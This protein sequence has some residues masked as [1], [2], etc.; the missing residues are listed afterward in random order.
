VLVAYASRDVAL[1]VVQRDFG[2]AVE[3]AELAVVAEQRTVGAAQ[4]REL[5]AVVVFDDRDTAF[6]GLRERA[7][8]DFA[9]LV[10]LRLETGGLA[11]DV[12]FFG[13]EDARRVVLLELA[14]AVA[15][16]VEAADRGV[17]VHIDRLAIPERHA[18]AIFLLRHELA[19]VAVAAL[20]D[21][22]FARVRG[23]VRGVHVLAVHLAILHG[24]NGRREEQ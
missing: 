16:F 10:E 1:G 2:G 17:A 15:V 4:L 12:T 19:A 11:V 7:A 3:A 22:R 21:P 14:V 6:A 13:D 5:A 9:V 20:H 8:A 24:V 18:F 23:A